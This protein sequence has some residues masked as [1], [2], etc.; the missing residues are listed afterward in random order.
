MKKCYYTDVDEVWNTKPSSSTVYTDQN[1]LGK[2]QTALRHV[3]FPVLFLCLGLWSCK[4]EAT[5][6]LSADLDPAT[7]KPAEEAF[8]AKG[9]PDGQIS[10]RKHANGLA[11]AKSFDLQRGDWPGF[12]LDWTTRGPANIGA[13]INTFAVHPEND[14]IMLVGFSRGGVW[15]TVDGGQNWEPIFDEQTFLCIGDIAFDPSNPNTIYVGLGD[16]NISSNFI[17]GDGIYRSTDGGDSWENI[18]WGGLNI[19]S[20]IRVHPTD[21][22]IIYAAAMGAPFERND[23]RGLYRTIDGGQNWE[24]VLFASEQAGIIDMVMDHQNPDILYASSWDRIRNNQESIVNGPNAKVF[25][26]IDGGDNWT[27]LGGGL[28]TD[29][30]GRIGLT[31]TQ[32]DPQHLYAAYVGTNNQLLDIFETMD[33]GLSWEG[34][35]DTASVDPISPSALGGFGWYFGKVRVHPQNPD[36]IY[37]LGVDLWRSRD[38]GQNW[39]RSTPPWFEYA[40]HA[41]KHDLQ[42]NSAG[43][44][45]LATDGGLYKGENDMVD[46]SDLESIPCTQFYRV[47]V[48]PH[49][50]GLVYGGAQDNGSTGGDNLAEEWPRIYGGD[51]FQMQFHPFNDGH[52]FAETQNGGI[53]VTLDDGASWSGARNGIMG[54]DRRNWDMQYMLSPHDPEIMYTGTYR[55]YQGFDSTDPLWQPISEDLTDGLI[56]HPRYHSI[57]SVDESPL[58]EGLLFVGTTDGNVWRGEE[59]SWTPI[60]DGLPDRYISSVKA[61]PDDPEKVYVTMS[62]YKDYDFSPLVFRSDDRGETWTSIAG[63][64]P[65]LAINDI[66]VYPGTGDSLIFIASDGGVYGTRT[67]GESW[68]RLGENMPFVAVKDLEIDFVTNELV[69]G[70]FARSILTYPLDSLVSA[71]LVS[72]DEPV[73]ATDLR[74]SPN[75]TDGFT[76][77]SWQGL[78]N[79]ASSVRVLNL[80]GQLIWSTNFEPQGEAGT[81]DIVLPEGTPNGMY[82]VQLEQAGQRQ[83]LKLLYSR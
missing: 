52:F 21:S 55:V 73:W 45:I 79:S 63:D 16:P 42:W 82:V 66:Y 15:R 26:S 30:Q 74:L 39:Q 31:M 14:D 12:E 46:W 1:S 6:P 48:N 57:T 32:Q 40:V 78:A 38:G 35:L 18:G 7:I 81:V 71:P 20:Q 70:S 34:V 17:V 36:D 58:E 2:A 29:E 50:P 28:P 62:A 72:T 61:S 25:K 68:Q 56:L 51:G 3:Y 75:P 41:D 10:Y 24:Q 59:L 53:V 54:N 8:L 9:W 37:I 67:A 80:Q 60:N 33:G 11:E 83:A 22:D 49:R 65:D 69:A 5:H 76:Q 27:E 47:A 23:A 13:R 44:A 77:L 64:L 43:A 19:I 4:Q